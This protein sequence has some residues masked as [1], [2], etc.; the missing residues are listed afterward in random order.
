MRLNNLRAFGILIVTG[1][2][3]AASLNGQVRS[4]AAL[5]A[6]AESLAGSVS[7]DLYCASCHG[8]SGEGNGPAASSLRSTPADLTLLARRSGG[9]FPRERVTATIDGSSGSA[10][11]GS[12]D[13]PV[14]GPMFRA[15]EPDEREAVRLRN[16]V[17]F[18]A[19][20]QRPA[21]APAASVT[22]PDGAAVYRDYCFSCHGPGARGN[23]PFTFALKVVPPNLT[24]LAQRNGGA[25][26]RDRVRNVV[27]GAGLRSHGD[28]EMPVYG[29]LL[30]RGRPGDSGAAARIDAVVTY[31][32]SIQDGAPRPARDR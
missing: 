25:F 6:Q 26:P 27:E 10:T 12:P 19:S 30:R 21:S 15:M 14:W 9:T 13:M 24:T 22:D 17:A 2:A 1:L 3:A 5:P 20:I 28:R 4:D 18:V 8:R 7:F 23:G 11:H 29:S 31:L 32:E 16:L